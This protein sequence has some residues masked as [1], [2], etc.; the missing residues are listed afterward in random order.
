MVR[1][2]DLRKMSKV[3]LIDYIG[4]VAVQFEINVIEIETMGK[5]DVDDLVIYINDIEGNLYAERDSVEEVKAIFNDTYT[6]VTGR[7]VKNEWR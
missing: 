4:K 2:S 7:E 5:M 3:D 1:L 6:K